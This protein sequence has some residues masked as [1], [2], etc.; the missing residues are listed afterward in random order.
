MSTQ[1]KRKIGIFTGTRA[2]YGLLYWIIKLLHED[3]DLELQLIVGGMHLSNKFGRTVSQIERDG[4]P[5]TD[6]LDFLLSSDT[7][8][9]IS[10]SMGLAIISASECFERLRPDIIVLLGDRFEAMAIA[11]AALIAKIPIAHI[12]GGESTEGLIDEAI[13]HSITKMSQ[14]HFTSTEAYKNRVIQLGERPETVFNFGAPGIDT[15]NKLRLLSREKLGDLICF[16]FDAPYFLL[17]YHPVTLEHNG[18]KQGLENL[19]SVLNNYPKH[20]I[21]ITYPNADT[22]S[23]Y[24]LDL[25]KEY[26]KINPKRVFLFQSLGQLK[27]LSL[28]KYCSAVIGNSSSGLIEA[29]TFGV[30]TINIGNRQKGRIAGNTVIHTDET[31]D[32]ISKGIDM[33]LSFNFIKQCQNSVNPYGN[34]N[35]SENIV[36]IL[37]KIDLNNIIAKP[38]YDVEFKK[39]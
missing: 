5:I 35:A 38:F 11:Q 6:R 2:E 27:Y 14:I 33:A 10:K 4:F 36:N 24:L 22:D 9:G 3:K 16:D 31:F 32:S 21:I 25:I 1:I 28:I 7:V 26:Q 19:F 15:I 30:P 29:P 17:T 20:K 18:A 34:G 39:H 13:R 23:N 8:T 12:H 37:R